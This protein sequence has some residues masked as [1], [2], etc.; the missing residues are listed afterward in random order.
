MQLNS[1]DF[2]NIIHIMEVHLTTIEND[3]EKLGMLNVVEQL[4]MDY[5]TTLEKVKL[6]RTHESNRL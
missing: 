2:E 5:A 3:Y 1:R 4:L 6:L